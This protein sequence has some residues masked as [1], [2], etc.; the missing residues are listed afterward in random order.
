MIAHRPALALPGRPAPH[1]PAHAAAPP[2]PMP[3]ARPLPAGIPIDWMIVSLALLAIVLMNTIPMTLLAHLK[4]HYT[5]SGGSALEKFHP[6]S[7]V[8]VL[9]FCLTLLRDGAPVREMDRM[10]AAAP[11]ILLYAFSILLVVIQSIAFGRPVTGAFDA[12]LLPLVAFLVI[13]GLSPAQRRPLAWALQLLLLLNIAL[14]YFE[15]VSGHR[16]VPLVTDNNPALVKEWRATALLGHPLSASGLVGAYVL[17]LMFRPGLIPQPALR[18]SVIVFSLGSLFVFGGRTSLV[19]VLIATGF[20]A[21]RL[22]FRFARGTRVPLAF[23]IVAICGGFLLA[24][25][26]LTLFNVGFLD[27]MLLRFSS[28]NGSAWARVASMQLLMSLDWREILLG[29]DAVRLESLQRLLGIHVGIEDFWFASIAQYGLIVTIVLTI[30]LACFFAEVLRRT[31]PAARLL[32]AFL[33]VMAAGSI[34]FSAKGVTLAQYVILMLLL[35]PRDRPARTPAAAPAGGRA[36][37]ASPAHVRG[38]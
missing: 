13:V 33:V 38:S 36:R 2:R 30:G 27:Q 12:F 8:F 32:V 19:L 34:T 17:A 4:I 37:L 5:T 24:A 15:H 11:L 7:Y 29:V 3:H 20:L 16:I 22:A 6:A 35:L 25:V 14:A 31:H 1:G 28:D 26:G 21:A 9:A 10:I 23:V 18:A